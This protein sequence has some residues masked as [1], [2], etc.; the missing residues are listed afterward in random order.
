M[1]LSHRAFRLADLRALTRKC[2]PKIQQPTRE[3]AEAQVQDVITHGLHRSS[4]IHAY[5]CPDC[6]AWHAG[7]AGRTR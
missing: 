3:A 7:H 1:I 6:G 4:R 5:E 2:Y